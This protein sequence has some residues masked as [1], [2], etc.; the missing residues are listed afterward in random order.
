MHRWKVVIAGYHRAQ[1]SSEDNRVLQARTR[2]STF[3][4]GIVAAS[5]MIQSLGLGGKS[6]LH[7]PIDH[8]LSCSSGCTTA[9]RNFFLF[10]MKSY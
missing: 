2:L 4:L 5:G 7:H 6:L 9:L 1:P 10:M 3:H 8:C